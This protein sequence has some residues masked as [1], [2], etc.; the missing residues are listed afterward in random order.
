MNNS[1]NAIYQ[2][3]WDYLLD[4]KIATDEEIETL[5]KQ[6]GWSIQLL[7]TILYLKTG[8]QT[9]NEHIEQ[10]TPQTATPKKSE[11]IL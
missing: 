7:Q 8:C 4:Y 1:Q 11:Y 3:L 2:H 10:H 6:H 5:T 9:F